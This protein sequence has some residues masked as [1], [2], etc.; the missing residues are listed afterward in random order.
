ML[1][2]DAIAGGVA[3]VSATRTISADGVIEEIGN[4]PQESHS[5][6][7]GPPRGFWGQGVFVGPATGPRIFGTSQA[8][9]SSAVGVFSELEVSNVGVT[10]YPT[11]IFANVDVQD[12]GFNSEFTA[13]A[14]SILEMVFTVAETAD[15][16]LDVSLF[17]SVLKEQVFTSGDAV[18]LGQAQ[19]AL[20]GEVSGCFLSRTVSDGRADGSSEIFDDT[21]EQPLGAD[22]YTFSIS[23]RTRAAA[24][25]DAE[26]SAEASFEVHLTV[27]PEPAASVLSAMALVVLLVIRAREELSLGSL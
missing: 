21:I 22:T 26:A 25:E 1:A 6:A 8:E 12:P 19:F 15:L 10:A 23:A 5:S 17:A 7:E 13:E 18:A 24:Q 14:E 11:L 16:T 2:S 9:Q 4:S 20:C 3:F 27:L